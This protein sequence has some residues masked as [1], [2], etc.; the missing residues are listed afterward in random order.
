MTANLGWLELGNNRLDH[1]PSHALR[2]LHSLRQLD[3]DSNNI[4]YVQMDAFKGY[5]DTLRYIVL[6]KNQ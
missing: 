2:P 1:I 4:Q 3:L 6:D 5:G